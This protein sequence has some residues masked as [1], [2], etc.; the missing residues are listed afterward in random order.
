MLR[1]RRF[2]FAVSCTLFAACGGAIQE[3]DAARGGGGAQSTYAA[4]LPS[5]GTPYGA[6][7]L[8]S[9]EGMPGGKQS[10]QTV[11]NLFLELRSDGTAV[12]RRCTQ[13][14]FAVEES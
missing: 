12:A 10:T 4:P 13:P 9:L 11:G 1:M 8:V 6:W 14:Y 2:G 7:N 3:D 5:E